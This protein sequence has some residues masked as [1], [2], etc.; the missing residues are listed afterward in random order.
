M[1][2]SKSTPDFPFLAHPNHLAN[3]SRDFGALNT[4]SSQVD[5]PPLRHFA[6]WIVLIGSVIFILKKI[7]SLEDALSCIFGSK[8]F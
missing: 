5:K 2:P 3:S 1:P 6:G 8:P 7:L 4:Y